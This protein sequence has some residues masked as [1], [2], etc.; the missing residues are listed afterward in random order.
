MKTLASKSNTEVVFIS[1][2]TGAGCSTLVEI[3]ERLAASG[4]HR[5]TLLIPPQDGAITGLI[6]KDADDVDMDYRDDGI[7]CTC[8]VDDKLYAKIK[9]YIIEE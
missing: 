8:V 3:I 9:K 2:V 1:A 4:K 5:V 7:H 6:Y